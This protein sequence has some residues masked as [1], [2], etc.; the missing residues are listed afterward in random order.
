M[1]V[2]SLEQKETQCL[3]ASYRMS[4]LMPAQRRSVA[5]A[6]DAADDDDYL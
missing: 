2:L 5:A 6:A 1:H 3:R 4:G